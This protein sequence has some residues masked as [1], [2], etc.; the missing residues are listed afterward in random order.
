L[1]V[2]PTRPASPSSAAAIAAQALSSR[3]AL[4]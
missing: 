3:P 2:I 4:D 1:T